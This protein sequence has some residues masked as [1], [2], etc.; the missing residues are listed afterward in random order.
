MPSSRP[1]RQRLLAA[2]AVLALASG[3][4]YAQAVNIR[5][6]QYEVVA[7]VN[8]ALP[9]EAAAHLPPEILAKLQQPQVSEQCITDADAASASRH[10]AQARQQQ[11][12]SS[13]KVTAQSVTGSEIKITTQCGASTTNIDMVFGGDSFHGTIVTDTGNAAPSS[14]KLQAHRIGDCSK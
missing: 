11:P 13:C 3:L 12:D 5:P 9:P 2:C 7:Q 10:L 6:G 14:V 4:L 1:A 8:L